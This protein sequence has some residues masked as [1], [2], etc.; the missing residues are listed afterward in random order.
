MKT[1]LTSI[2][3]LILICG[4]IFSVNR[5][6][7]VDSATNSIGATNEPSPFKINVTPRKT[8]VHA[9]E[10]FKV[11]LEVKNVSNTNQTFKVWSCSWWENW[12]SS[13]PAVRLV[14]WGCAENGPMKVNL[15]PGESFKETLNGKEADLEVPQSVSTNKISFHM[16][17]HTGASIHL[18]KPGET[19]PDDV[20]GKIYYSNEVTIS[21]NPKSVPDWIPW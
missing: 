8:R 9:G 5:I 17:F 1:K 12:S 18:Y 16:V 4:I 20:K 13:N 15:A 10:K 6:F 21:I 7:A 19:I 14:G 2:T 3:R 11:G